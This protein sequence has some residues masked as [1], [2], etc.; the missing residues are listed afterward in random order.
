M[1]KE[2]TPMRPTIGCILVVF[3]IAVFAIPIQGEETRQLRQNYTINIEVACVD[4]ATEIIRQLPGYNLDSSASFDT[5]HRRV[6]FRRRVSN[7]DFRHV[8][9]VLRGL[10]DVTFETENAA[11]LGARLLDLD[12]SIAVLEQELERLTAMMAASTTLDVLIAVNDRLSMVSRDR[13]NLIGQRNVLQV[14]SLGPIISI[15]LIETLPDAPSPTPLGFGRQ[16][17]DR[18]SHSISNVRTATENFMVGV[19]RLALP[20]IVWAAILAVVGFVIWRLFCRK[21][22]HKMLMKKQ[23]APVMEESDKPKGEAE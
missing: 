5:W 3:C 17:A 12:V 23:S 9:E 4:A 14:E 19:V 10:G 1:K 6:D 21:I 22:W 11:H 8:Q 20:L 7:E 13:D 15:S 18:F 16:I 2:V